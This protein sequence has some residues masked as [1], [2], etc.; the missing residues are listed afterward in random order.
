MSKKNIA[1]YTPCVNDRIFKGMMHVLDSGE[2]PQ[3]GGSENYV[4]EVDYNARERELVE[5]IEKLQQTLWF[6]LPMSPAPSPEIAQ[7]VMDD[8]LLLIGTEEGP[9]A[10]SAESKGWV[11]F[12]KENKP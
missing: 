3:W 5:R 2:G 7:R 8:L 4:R 6:W 11:R 10:D 12:A 9:R 1:F